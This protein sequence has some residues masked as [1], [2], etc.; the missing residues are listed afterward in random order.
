M[1]GGCFVGCEDFLFPGPTHHPR[2]HPPYRCDCRRVVDV[3][4]LG[5]CSS[6]SPWRVH[7]RVGVWGIWFQVS[8]CSETPSMQCPA[9]GNTIKAAVQV[10]DDAGAAQGVAKGRKRLWDG[11]A[12]LSKQHPVTLPLEESDRY[13][14]KIDD[15]PAIPIPPAIP[16][17]SSVHVPPHPHLRALLHFFL[18]RPP[19]VP[20]AP[21]SLLPCLPSFRLLLCCWRLIC[22]CLCVRPHPLPGESASLMWLGWACVQADGRGAGK[23][24]S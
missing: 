23:N 4:N 14:P 5:H 8:V 15:T 24:V 13:T 16:K 2:Q 21:D 10:G 11:E 20:S 22:Q 17:P 9:L 19:S 6:V 1:R 18:P 3:P 12:P 7:L